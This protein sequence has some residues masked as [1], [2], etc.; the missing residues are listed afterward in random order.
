MTLTNRSRSPI[1]VMNHEIPCFEMRPNS[2]PKSNIFGRRR[3]RRKRRR[4]LRGIAL[5]RIGHASRNEGGK[6]GQKE[7]FVLGWMRWMPR[8]KNLR[9][10]GRKKWGSTS[11]NMCGMDRWQRRSFLWTEQQKIRVMWWPKMTPFIPCAMAAGQVVS[12]TLVLWASH[13]NS[14]DV[15]IHGVKQQSTLNMNCCFTRQLYSNINSIGSWWC[16]ECTGDPMVLGHHSKGRVQLNDRC[17]ICISECIQLTW[18][19]ART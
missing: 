14:I 2:T 7:H 11:R 6:E 9:W 18:E 1:R 8:C 15:Q 17:S 19:L 10:G 3:Q 16:G 13:T 5:G 4:N 12:P